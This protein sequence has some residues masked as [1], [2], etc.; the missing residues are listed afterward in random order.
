VGSVNGS[1]KGP[2][3]LKTRY[4]HTYRIQHDPAAFHEPG[5]RKDP[6]LYV[7]PCR[8]GHIYVHSG[9]QLAL[10]WNSRKWLD[11]ICPE[12]ELYQD[13]DEEKVYLFRPEDFEA[14]AKVAMPRRRRQGRPLSPVERQEA[15]QRLR[16]HWFPQKSYSA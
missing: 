13:G 15:V 10:W 7:I 11:P 5:G 4:G 12:L 3:D 2:I 9:T 16:Q 14:V 6:W 1:G 8:K